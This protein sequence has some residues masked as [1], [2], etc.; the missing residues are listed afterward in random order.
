MYA[1]CSWQQPLASWTGIKVALELSGDLALEVLPSVL[2]KRRKPSCHSSPTVPLGQ[3]ALLLDLGSLLHHSFLLSTRLDLNEPILM[4][5]M[6][7]W[8]SLV[9]ELMWIIH[10]FI[11]NW[12]KKNTVS[13]VIITSRIGVFP[14]PIP[15]PCWIAY[16]KY[17]YACLYH[18][19][20]NDV[21]LVSVLITI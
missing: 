4:K 9:N 16:F 5:K 20:M 21:F 10:F 3:P 15:L 7:K 2:E 13:S 11:R 6:R 8:W 1:S 18:Y 14:S 19:S 17:L 12:S